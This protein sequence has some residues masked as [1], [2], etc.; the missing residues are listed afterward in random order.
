M[1]AEKREVKKEGDRY[2][3]SVVLNCLWRVVIY[4]LIFN[5]AVV[6]HVTADLQS[7]LQWAEV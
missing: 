1:A 2:C 5:T 7:W 4:C 3:V 6:V